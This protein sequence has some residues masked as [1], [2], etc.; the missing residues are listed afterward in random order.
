[1]GEK[2]KV[3]DITTGEWQGKLSDSAMRN[4]IRK[5]NAEKKQPAFAPDKL[6]DQALRDV[7]AYIR[8][9]RR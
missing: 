9:L 5:G 3:T 1:M 8:T 7:V 6:D 2:L 4:A